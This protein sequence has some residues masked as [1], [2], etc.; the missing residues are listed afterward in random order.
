MYPSKPS[1]T[2]KSKS[3]LHY[4]LHSNLH[5]LTP[6]VINKK[7]ETLVDKIVQL[8]KK[9][10]KKFINMTNETLVKEVNSL[11][12]NDILLN[13]DFNRFMHLIENH[14][15]FR[16]GGSDLFVE[17]TKDISNR[18]SI[19]LTE[20]SNNNDYLNL[21]AV[22][23]K[24]ENKIDSPSTSPKNFNPL[25]SPYDK[26]TKLEELKNIKEKDNWAL[27]AKQDYEK[28]LDE[29]R[30]LKKIDDKKKKEVKDFLSQQ[31]EEKNTALKRKKENDTKFEI[32]AKNDYDNWKLKEEIKKNEKEQ[33][34]KQMI[35]M[36]DNL[37]KC[38]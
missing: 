5:S 24:I 15:N 20:S 26:K 22:D 25:P 37:V 6:K 2:N 13:F 17:N 18:K 38:M 34:I 23:S 16:D 29:K 12:T 36:R 10:Y 27:L 11:L 3:Q 32:S 4:H 21:E 9:K 19:N 7:K 35:K 30:N 28:F 1:S 33:K 31:I 8:L 14:F